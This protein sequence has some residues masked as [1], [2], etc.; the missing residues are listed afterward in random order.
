MPTR[1]FPLMALLCV[2]C[3]VHAQSEKR[4]GKQIYG[5][6]T[7]LSN[8]LDGLPGSRQPLNGWDFALGFQSWHG[9]R[10][11]IDTYSYRGS[12]L[13]APQDLLFIL[14]G[15]QYDRK[16][17]K[18][19]IFAEVYGGNASANKNW[20][21][22][23]QRGSADA[24]TNLMGG[25]LDTPLSGHLAFR[26]SGGYQHWDFALNNPVTE[27]FYQYPGIPNNF[28]RISSGLVWKF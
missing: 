15:A 16:I 25:G 10:F 27:T 6:Y 1:L 18:E 22:N 13:G 12:N 19:I 20:G 11:K 4:T 17:G 21:P 26:V 2:S 9:L 14:A 3:V 24:F 23:G 5:G 8:S 28:G 7:L